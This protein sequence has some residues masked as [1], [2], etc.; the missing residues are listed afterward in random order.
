[1]T[2]SSEA[3]EEEEEVEKENEMAEDD[4]MHFS[5][6]L[7]LQPNF[8]V[9]S[10]CCISLY[11]AVVPF[12][13]ISSD[14]L[15]KKWH[16]S[17]TKAGTIM[18]IPD[19]VSSVGS[20]VCGYLVDR[21]GNRARYIPLSAVFI[22]CAHGLFGFTVISPVVAMVILG[23]AYS[24]FASVLWPCIPFLVEDH[25][26]GTAYG[27]VTI[28][29]N[30]SLTFFPMI[31]AS[32]LHGGYIQLTEQAPSAETQYPEDDYYSQRTRRDLSQQQW[33]QRHDH[34]NPR[35]PGFEYRRHRRFSEDLL[36]EED[37]DI[38][39][40]QDMV[41]TRP[42]GEGIITIIPHRRRHSMAGFAGHMELETKNLPAVNFSLSY[43][44]KVINRSG[45]VSVECMHGALECEGNKQQLCFRKFFPDRETWFPFV[46]RMN[47]QPSRVGDVAF[48][49]EAGE[50]IGGKSALLGKVEECAGGQEGLDLLIASVKNTESHDAK[51]SCTVFINNKKRCVVDGGVWR[52]CPGG[53]TVP[54]F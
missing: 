36:Q 6:I 17:P 8:W 12:N 39:D 33:I 14:F 1:M 9:L 43:F 24:L 29:L 37:P 52:E 20:P 10:L 27:L 13:H 28:A 15:Q 2:M 23:L 31:V 46:L 53:S 41:T 26:L 34:Y 3:L 40:V 4:E 19:I 45:K 21:F 32:I 5:E 35:E 38:E 22:I 44:G 42:V 18:S 16:M 50:A 51:A 49:R 30:I 11:G 7:T 47:S 48:A 54:D 25:Q